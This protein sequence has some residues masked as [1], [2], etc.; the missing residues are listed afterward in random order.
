[1]EIKDGIFEIELELLSDSADDISAG[2]Q[3]IL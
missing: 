2:L 3:Y 1:V